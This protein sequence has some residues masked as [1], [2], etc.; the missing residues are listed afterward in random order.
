MVM[1]SIKIFE[2]P[3]YVVLEKEDDLNLEALRKEV[4]E[5]FN[6]MGVV[7]FPDVSLAARIMNRMKAYHDYRLSTLGVQTAEPLGVQTAEPLGV[8]TAEPL[9]VQTA[10][11][12]GSTG[13][14]TGSRS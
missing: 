9:G 8:Q 6:A 13:R 11:P 7:A 4:A 12:R 1:E 14:S 2:K 3:C 10:E 5:L